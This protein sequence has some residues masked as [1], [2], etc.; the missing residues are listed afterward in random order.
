MDGKTQSVLGGEKPT[1]LAHCPSE[2]LMDCPGIK[3]GPL[4]LQ[5]S[6]NIVV[7]VA[8]EMKQLQR[9]CWDIV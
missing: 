6:E 3:S 2:F 5:L 8:A 7:Q 1:P 4:R 9:L